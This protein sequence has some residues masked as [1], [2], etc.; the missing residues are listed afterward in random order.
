MADMDGLG[1]LM[2]ISDANAPEDPD[3]V[4]MR[5]GVDE[6]GHVIDQMIETRYCQIKNAIP[7]ENYL[8]IVGDDDFTDVEIRI[9]HKTLE[10]L[11]WKR[12]AS[13]TDERQ[14]AIEIINRFSIC[15]DHDQ[16]SHCVECDLRHK[17]IAAIRG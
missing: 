8:R 5:E 10:A 4:A 6:D 16:P 3:V 17:A 15:R 7:A 14:R 11:G 2:E 9:H 13:E 12:S 1:I